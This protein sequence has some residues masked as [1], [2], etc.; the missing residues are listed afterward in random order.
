MA[1]T[2]DG[3]TESELRRVLSSI[4]HG[5]VTLI[6]QDGKVIQIDATHTLRLTNPKPSSEASREPAHR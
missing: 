3:D 6:V 4:R 5:S 1:T 2:L